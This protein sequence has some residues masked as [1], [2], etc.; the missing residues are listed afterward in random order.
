MD[1]DIHDG[2]LIRGERVTM[3][4][5]VRDAAAC[6][7]TFAVR[8]ASAR[9]VLAYAGVDV[10]EP[11]RGAALCSLVFVRYTDGDLGPYHEFGVAFLIRAPVGGGLGAFVHWLP[12]NQPFTLEAGR[13]IWGFPKELADIRLEHAGRA[14]R[15]VVRHEGRLAVDLLVRPGVP[16]PGRAAAASVDAY[17]CLDGVLRRTPWSLRARRVRTRPGGAVLRLGDHPVADELRALGLPRTAL[18]GS[19]IGRLEMTFAGAAPVA[20]VR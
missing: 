3:P 17:T 5:R 11:W 18:A 8:A 7:A 9:S 19:T 15:C 10:A 1:G 6:S 2:H 4:V 12:V 20:A 16:T 14:R 13:S